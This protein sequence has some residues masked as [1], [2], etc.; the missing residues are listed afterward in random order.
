MLK[1]RPF[2]IE[3]MGDLHRAYEEQEH[4]VVMK[5][6]SAKS[7]RKAM[8]RSSRLPRSGS[9][10][11]SKASRHLAGGRTRVDIEDLTWESH[12]HGRFGWFGPQN[13]QRLGFAGLGLKTRG[14][15]GER[16][17]RIEGHVTVS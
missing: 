4:I 14:A 5:T 1:D 7:G 13:H 16:M 15:S 9:A 12:G 10:K 11:D 8:P 2:R 17:A 6:A 3:S